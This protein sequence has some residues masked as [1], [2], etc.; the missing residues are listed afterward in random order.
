MAQLALDTS[1]ESPDYPAAI[2]EAI[3]THPYQ[4]WAPWWMQGF[5]YKLPPTTVVDSSC[6][7]IRHNGR[8]WDMDG[9]GWADVRYFLLKCGAFAHLCKEQYTSKC[10]HCHYHRQ[11]FFKR[12]IAADTNMTNMWFSEAPRNHPLSGIIELVFSHKPSIWRCTRNMHN[13]PAKPTFTRFNMGF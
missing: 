2:R 10:S 5:M 11:F 12:C 6:T 4:R 8:I 7:E 9:R 1:H 3:G 13:Q